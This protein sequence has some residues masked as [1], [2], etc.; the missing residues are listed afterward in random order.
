[1]SASPTPQ[2]RRQAH[3]A[4][5]DQLAAATYKFD[6]YQTMRRMACADPSL[7]LPGAHPAAASSA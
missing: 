5:L 1:M 6:F 2:Q 7:P 3:E 4:W